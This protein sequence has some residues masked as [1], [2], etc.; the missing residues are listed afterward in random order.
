MFLPSKMGSGYHPGT[1]AE[2]DLYV[3]YC[4]A[5]VDVIPHSFLSVFMFYFE[6]RT[7][8]RARSANADFLRPAYLCVVMVT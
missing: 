7:V 2:Y 5:A 1:S 4:C 8:I 3:C 6:V